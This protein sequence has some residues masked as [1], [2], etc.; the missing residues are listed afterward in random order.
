M[1]RTTPPGEDATRGQRARA[2]PALIDGMPP[3]EDNVTGEGPAR[4][5]YHTNATRGR[6]AEEVQRNSLTSNGASI[7]FLKIVSEAEEQALLYTNQANRRAWSDALKAYHNEHYNGSKYNRQEWRNRSKLFVPKTRSAVRKDMAAV[8]ASLFGSVDAVNCS[9]GN[10]ADPKQ[11]ASASVIQELVNYRTDRT[12]GR[13]SMPWFLIAMGAR[14]DAMM[15]GICLSKQYWKLELKQRGGRWGPDIDRPDIHLFAPENYVI[16]PAADWLNPA[17][18]AAFLILKYPMRVD[19]IERKQKHPIP[20][21]RWKNVSKDVL[22]TSIETA[23]Y[24]QAAIRRARESGLDRYDETQTGYKFKVIWVFENFIRMDGEDWHFWS[25]SDKDYLTEPRPVEEVY[26][27]QFGERPVVKGYGAIDSHRIFPMAPVDSW[28]PL[29]TEVNDLRNLALDQIKQNVMPITKVVRGRQIDVDQ[30]KRRSHGSSIIVTN[31]DDVTWEQ[32]PQLPASVPEMNRD[33]ELEFDDLSGVANAATTANNNA[34][35]RTLGGLKLVAGAANAVQEFDIRVW[36]TTW[37]DPVLAQLVRLEQYYE[38]D[39]VVLGLCGERAQLFQKYGIDRIDDDLLE[40]EVTIRVSIGLGA[41]DPQARLAK[42]QTATQIAA[43]LLAQSKEFQTGE[44]Q[45]DPEAVMQ[46]VYGAAGYRDGGMRF[47]KKGQPQPNPM[48]DL[49]VQKLQADI[50][51]TKAQGRASLMTGLAAL[52]KVE[53]G[54][55]ELEAMN[56]NQLMEH[57]A[58]AHEMGVGHAH[59]MHDRLMAALEHGHRHGLALRQ[60]SLAESQHAQ[61]AQQGD[62][63]H[64]LSVAQHGLAV[65]QHEHQVG[66]DKAAF[67]HQVDQDNWSR[68]QAEAEA[69]AGEGGGGK[70]KPPKVAAKMPPS[71]AP[72]PQPQPQDNSEIDQKLDQMSQQIAQLTQLVGALA[73]QQQR[74]SFPAQPYGQ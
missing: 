53:L 50:E 24:D 17:Q 42:F 51:K 64:G 72:R 20:A 56:A 32:P 28:R 69:Q 73:Q 27:E 37:G 23:K 71:P 11:R 45:I 26:P 12:S 31:K 4:E 5:A 61:A 70:K 29:Q 74:P 35:G 41:G 6:T 49:P 46:E 58:R 25:I 38:S 48:G 3:G 13:A 36:I 57:Y 62:Q 9:A 22:D 30:I 60:H 39:P 43:P 18:S 59:D 16:D 55:R 63:E 1:L 66:Q 47:I 33:L 67:A 54:D 15:T 21:L 34:L 65:D 10:E 2:V 44:W 52:A 40:Q 8:S 19:E 7:D 14:Q 68:A